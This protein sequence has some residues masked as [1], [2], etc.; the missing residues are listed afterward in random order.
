MSRKRITAAV[1][2]LTVIGVALAA[3]SAHAVTDLEKF[4]KKVGRIA[5]LQPAGGLP[6]RP[7]G[8][9]FCQSGV[10]ALHTG[11]L[12]QF[13]FGNYVRMQC[14]TPLFDAAGAASG[15]INCD[16]PWVQVSK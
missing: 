12:T 4:Q 8:L 14:V 10:A 9:C 3:A 11:Y 15:F 5:P 16:G 13:Q 6:D 2:V 1:R 7:A